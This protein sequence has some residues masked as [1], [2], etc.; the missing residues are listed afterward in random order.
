MNL[1]NK[2]IVLLPAYNEGKALPALFNDIKK[3]LG[4]FEYHVVIV[5]DGSTDNTVKII[6]DW[7][8]QIS[9]ELLQQEKNQGLGV[10]VRRGLKYIS[11]SF[12]IDSIVVTL[13]ADN[14]HNPKIIPGLVEE[15]AQGYDVTIASRFCP[16]GRE[17]GVKLSRKIFSRGAK[18]L[19]S[20]LFSIPGVKDYTCGY[21]AYKL[22]LIKKGFEV[23]GDQFVAEDGFAC[24]AEILIKTSMLGAKITEVP[25]V[26]RYDLKQGKSKIK[27]IKTILEYYHL[28]KLKKAIRQAPVELNHVE[29]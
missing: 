8:Q 24:M 4:E 16:G 17:E 26:L 1:R 14:T 20:C 28:I 22:S 11:H 5:D 9:M 21:R 7:Q 29:R 12:P 27:V 25:L 3:Y 13:D 18:F 19:L 10:A 15:I 6:K 23:F 2:I